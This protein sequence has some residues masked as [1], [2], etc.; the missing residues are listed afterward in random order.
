MTPPANQFAGVA[1]P[2]RAHGDA[3]TSLANQMAGPRHNSEPAAAHHLLSLDGAAHTGAGLDGSAHFSPWWR[4]YSKP[5]LL[6]WIAAIA[7]AGHT[8]DNPGAAGMPSFHAE[9]FRP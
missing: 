5:S 8:N 2:F 4:S 9:G 1:Y 6:S 7:D 3:R